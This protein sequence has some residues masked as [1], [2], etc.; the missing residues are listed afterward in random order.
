M[1]K[2]VFPWIDFGCF[3]ARGPLLFLLYDSNRVSE[4]KSSCWEGSS[5]SNSES[6]L[7]YQGDEESRFSDMTHSCHKS[8]G[9]HGS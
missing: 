8:G 3:S 1:Y 4:L 2:E 5:K 7:H 6:C 9:H